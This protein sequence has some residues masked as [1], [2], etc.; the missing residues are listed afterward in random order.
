MAGKTALV[1]D[2]SKSARFALRKYL[3]A[4]Q[5]QVNAVESAEEAYSYL[6]KSTPDVIFLDHMMPGTDG[7]EALTQIKQG[8][9]TSSIPVVIC[10][11]N[12]G[13]AFVQDAR[14]R[15]AADV[16]QKPPSPEL[17]QRILQ[18]LPALMPVEQEPVTKRLAPVIP[19]ATPSKVSNI[20]EPEVAIEQAVMKVL[21]GSMPTARGEPT[22]PSVPAYAQEPSTITQ[23]LQSST[24]MTPAFAPTA[25]GSFQVAQPPSPPPAAPTFNPNSTGSFNAGQLAANSQLSA[26]RDQI[27]ARVK[28]LTQDLFVQVAELKAEVANLE[29]QLGNQHARMDEVEP[30]AHDMIQAALESVQAHMQSMEQSIQ[31]RMQSLEMAVQ[32]QLRTMYTQLEGQLSH[33]SQN[34]DV[35]AQ[36]ARA[37][38]A[39]EAHAVAERVVMSAASRIAD[40]MAHSI[41]RAFHQPAQQD[42]L[43]RI[44]DQAFRAP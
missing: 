41:L 16:L 21:R 1:V 20:R 35:L 19:P 34:L 10:S 33:Q 32:S 25:T 29:S 3:E 36:G 22:L 39:E 18:G 23:R 17:L 42:E 12:E 11:S 9:Q 31:S 28:K 37:V 14:A 13:E 44:A 2:D 27:E 15:G 38:A 24:P 43:P 6:Q 40:T 30:R 8:A 26:V 4:H 7:F 5:F